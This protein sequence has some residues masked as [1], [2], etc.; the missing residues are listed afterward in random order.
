[1]KGIE[2]DGILPAYMGNL[3]HDHESKFYNYG[4]NNGT[5]G[6]HL[7]RELKGLQT[8]YNVSWAG[9]MS[10]FISGMND[11]KNADAAKGAQFC[12][13]QKL[14]E[15]ESKYDLIVK[16]GCSILHNMAE[17]TWGYAQ[18]KPMIKRLET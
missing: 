9:E 13:A 6:A 17:G 2:R 14:E 7:L 11:Y 5:C 16:N 8:L 1:M 18:L 10:A 4:K 15:F 3:C 12:D